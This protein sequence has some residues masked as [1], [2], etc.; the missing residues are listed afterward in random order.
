MYAV[1]KQLL[2][3]A[4]TMVDQKT[5]IDSFENAM[6]TIQTA[7]KGEQELL[8]EIMGGSIEKIVIDDE[9]QYADK[10][11]RTKAAQSGNIPMTVFKDR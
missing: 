4:V 3:L 7:C 2:K 8:L 6:L 1:S 10:Y 9:V 11:W 5:L